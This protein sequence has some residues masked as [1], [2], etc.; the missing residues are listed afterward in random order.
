MALQLQ[1][2]VM[3]ITITR[4]KLIAPVATGQLSGDQI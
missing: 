1:R 4:D 2:R 3:S